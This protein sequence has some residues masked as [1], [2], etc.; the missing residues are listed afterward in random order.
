M[1]E[2][3]TGRHISFSVDDRSYLSI[4]KREVHR[5]SVHIG[6]TEKKV[7][8]IDIVVAEIGSNIIKHAGRGEVLVMLTDHPQPALRS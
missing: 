5:L 1:E 6:L 3:I 2:W 4:L 7:A 8:E